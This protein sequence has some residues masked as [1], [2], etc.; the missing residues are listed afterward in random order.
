[1]V[2]LLAWVV[3]QGKT[4]RC[5]VSSMLAVNWQDFKVLVSYQMHRKV[6]LQTVLLPIW[7]TNQALVCLAADIYPE[8]LVRLDAVDDT[9]APSK[10]LA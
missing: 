2:W 3:Y 6:E 8:R 5:S 1:V 9:S 4:N 7:L 10:L